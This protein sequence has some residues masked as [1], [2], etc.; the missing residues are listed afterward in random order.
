MVMF[1]LKSVC[2]QLLEFIGTA[3]VT[4]TVVVVFVIVVGLIVIVLP[5]G[6]ISPAERN[7]CAVVV[8]FAA[9]AP[10]TIARR[11]PS[12]AANVVAFTT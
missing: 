5:V 2:V 4:V 8:A 12:Y 11:Q 10:G 7:A 6:L 3:T 9:V 1:L